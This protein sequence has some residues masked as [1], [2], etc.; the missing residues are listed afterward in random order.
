MTYEKD[1]NM[2][3]IAG[4]VNENGILR[5]KL[6]L[7]NETVVNIENVSRVLVDTNCYVI[8]IDQYNVISYPIDVVLSLKTEKVD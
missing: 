6:I 2:N 5:V 8:I 1:G 4:Y 7:R 3:N